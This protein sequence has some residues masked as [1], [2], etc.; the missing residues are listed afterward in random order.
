MRVHLKA[1]VVDVVNMATR[2]Q[3]ALKKDKVR[4]TVV[5]TTVGTGTM[6]ETESLEANATIAESQATR[7][8]TAGL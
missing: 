1:D 3:T 5:Q 2:K 4:T 6:G 7:R 8:Q